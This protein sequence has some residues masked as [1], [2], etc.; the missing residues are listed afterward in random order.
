M[1]R[2]ETGDIDTNYKSFRLEV[3]L[4]TCCDVTGVTCHLSSKATRKKTLRVFRFPIK[5]LLA[6]IRALTSV[7]TWHHLRE[8]WKDG[9][10]LNCGMGR[11]N[12]CIILTR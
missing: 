1:D 8:E 12:T 11:G 7:E 10:E 3:F 5:Y 9:P 6:H 4:V 2:I